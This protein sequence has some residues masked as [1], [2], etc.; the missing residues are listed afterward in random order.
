MPASRTIRLLY[1]GRQRDLVQELDS[2]WTAN[3]VPDDWD[4]PS[5]RLHFHWVSSQAQALDTLTRH[6]YRAILLNVD[7]R[8]YHRSRFCQDL[9]RRYP[10]MRICALCREPLKPTRFAF[11]GVL[12]LP[13]ESAEVLSILRAFCCERPE[14]HLQTGPIR[15]DVETRTLSGPRGRHLLPAKQSNL[16]RFLMQNADQL[17]SREEIMRVVWETEYLADTRTLDVHM[18]WLREKI[19]PDPTR[20]VHLITVRGQGFRLETG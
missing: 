9:R 20:P 5:V 4:I 8:R 12:H 17:V 6:S 14:L 1:L 15:L 18:R 10:E 16:L 11:D 7:T 19:E 2:V 13:L 3:S